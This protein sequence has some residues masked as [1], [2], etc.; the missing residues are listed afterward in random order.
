MFVTGLTVTEVR[1]AEEKYGLAFPPD[2]KEFLMFA[3]PVS[4]RWPNWRQVDDPVI[5]GMLAW[6]YEGICFDIEH[7]GFW[8]EDWGPKPAP[9]P[10]A[11]ALAQQKLSEAPKLIPICGH[12][13]LPDCPQAAGNPVF[14]IYQTDII[15][16]GANLVNYLENEFHY[17]FQTPEYNLEGSIRPIKFWSRL[18]EGK[19]D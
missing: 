4:G 19:A 18:A 11:F 15:Y 13:Y 16:Y 10:E 6:P 8:L 12:R 5:E 7:N 9:L 17:Y 2:L 14:S 1:R 3:L